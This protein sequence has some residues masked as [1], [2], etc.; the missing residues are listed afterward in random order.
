MENTKEMPSGVREGSLAE[1]LGKD[2]ARAIASVALAAAGLLGISGKPNSGVGVGVEVPNPATGKQVSVGVLVT[3]TEGKFPLGL[4]KVIGDKIDY[5][6]P[7]DLN[8]FQVNIG[9]AKLA[10]YTATLKNESGD[11]VKT[12]GVY[13]GFETQLGKK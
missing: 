2:K 4:P 6:Q 10:V 9:G 7:N 8:L 12:V 5:D 13:P 11:S 1:K 3:S